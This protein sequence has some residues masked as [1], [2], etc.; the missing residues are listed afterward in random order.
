MLGFVPI[1]T[2]FK[3]P[4]KMK[5][6]IALQNGKGFLLYSLPLLGFRLAGPTSSASSLFPLPQ[7]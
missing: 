5:F 6:K 1:K 4:L 3:N 7:A 2:E